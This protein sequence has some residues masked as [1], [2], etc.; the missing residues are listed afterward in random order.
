MASYARS[1]E[2]FQKE[3]VGLAAIVVDPPEQNRA[4]VAKLRLPF[5][6]LSDAESRVI[7]E[8]GVVNEKEMH[9][10]RPAIF[11]VRQDRSIGYRYVGEDFADRPDDDQLFSG[12]REGVH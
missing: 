10:A 1:W 4:M 7:R 3:G 5:P 6:I 12:L 8:W 2:R 11:G 9:I